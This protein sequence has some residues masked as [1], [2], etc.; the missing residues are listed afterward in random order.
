MAARAPPLFSETIEVQRILDVIDKNTG[1]P[2]TA[3]VRKQWI[4]NLHTKHL[5]KVPSRV[6]VRE[7]VNA[8]QEI[9]NQ[10]PA[11]ILRA[12]ATRA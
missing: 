2:F 11:A 7:R 3:A 8:I 12:A 5:H 1:R 6:F 9:V 10:I 4:E